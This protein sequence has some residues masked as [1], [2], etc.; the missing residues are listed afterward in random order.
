M[1][2]RT[3][4]CCHKFRYISNFTISGQALMKLLCSLRQNTAT[5]STRT[6]LSPMQ[7]KTAWNF[8]SRLEVIQGHTFW[9]HWKAHEGLRII[10]WTLEWKISEKDLSISCYKAPPSLS[11]GTDYLRNPREYSCKPYVSKKYRIFAAHSMGLSSFKC[12]WLSL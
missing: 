8:E 9:D 1:V 10:M 7:H 12:F 4:R 11:F 2:G 3:A 6:H 5:L